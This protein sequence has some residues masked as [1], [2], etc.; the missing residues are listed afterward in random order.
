M[1]GTLAVCSWLFLGDSLAVGFARH[2]PGAVDRAVVGNTPTQALKSHKRDLKACNGPVLISLGSNALYGNSKQEI[3]KI[4]LL[5]DTALLEA[6][7]VVIMPIP[8][9]GK[10]LVR[11]ARFN[12]AFR[13]WPDVRVL[14]DLDRDRCLWKDKI[15]VKPACFKLW[16][17][18][19]TE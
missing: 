7:E 12:E 11:A 16:A 10:Y 18:E 4:R 8:A 2:V 19:L 14:S 5:V 13:S 6:R 3:A 9:G 15:H 17:K 1:I